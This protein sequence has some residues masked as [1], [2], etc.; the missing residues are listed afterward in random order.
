MRPGHESV[1]TERSGTFVSPFHYPASRHEPDG[2]TER[3]SPEARHDYRVRR[4]KGM[5][6][7]RM[8]SARFLG[9][10]S[11]QLI[12]PLLLLALPD[13]PPLGVRWPCRWIS[14]EV[15]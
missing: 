5:R 11:C 2:F 3:R 10:I 9:Q 8:N 13:M 7:G 14:H 6:R 15:L 4:T 12:M 1:E